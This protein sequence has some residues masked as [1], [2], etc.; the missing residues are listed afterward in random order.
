MGDFTFIYVDESSFGNRDN[1]PQQWVM[2][3]AEVVVQ[4]NMAL[5]NVNLV[6]AVSGEGIVHSEVHLSS[7]NSEDF[8][9][10]IRK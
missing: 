7:T 5:R 6:L 9:G 3:G 2:S 4:K 1:L 10:F 8:L